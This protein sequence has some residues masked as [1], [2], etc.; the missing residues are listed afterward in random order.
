MRRGFLGEDSTLL[1]LRIYKTFK[2]TSL[3]LLVL[4]NFMLNVDCNRNA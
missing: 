4:L 3:A 1:F 2:Y